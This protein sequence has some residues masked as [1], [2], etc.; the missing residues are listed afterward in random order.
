MPYLIY[1]N[2]E[3]FIEKIGSYIKNPEKSSTKK[4]RKQTPCGYSMSTMSIWLYRK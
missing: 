3:S 1:V 4:I 2:I